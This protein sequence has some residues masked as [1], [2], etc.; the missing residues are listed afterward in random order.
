MAGFIALIIFS[1]HVAVLTQTNNTPNTTIDLKS[2]AVKDLT[3]I[4]VRQALQWKKPL[5]FI[6]IREP[7]FIAFS[8]MKAIFRSLRHRDCGPGTFVYDKLDPKKKVASSAK[9]TYT[10]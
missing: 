5:D 4:I 10:S 2:P 6:F 8:Y 3:N 1:M 7:R 9:Q